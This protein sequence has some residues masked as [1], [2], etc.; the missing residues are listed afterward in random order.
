MYSNQIAWP[1]SFMKLSTELNMSS[2]SITSQLIVGELLIELIGDAIKTICTRITLSNIIYLTM[3]I[4]S[5]KPW[6]MEVIVQESVLLT[7]SL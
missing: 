7:N 6:S 1:L 4:H 3:N 2:I 5:S